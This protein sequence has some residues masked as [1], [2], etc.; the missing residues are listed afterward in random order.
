MY[1]KLVILE[2]NDRKLTS[3]A[4][5]FG[6]ATLAEKVF[7]SVLQWSDS[8]AAEIPSRILNWIA[9]ITDKNT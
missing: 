5:E 8:P 6:S 2:D 4:V 9:V 7:L 1:K 3:R